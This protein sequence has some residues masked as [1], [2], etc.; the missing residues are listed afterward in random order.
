MEVKNQCQFNEMIF[1]LI[2]QCMVIDHALNQN[3]LK[4]KSFILKIIKIYFQLQFLIKGIKIK[5]EALD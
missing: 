1:Q 5:I 2:Q 4:R 3:N